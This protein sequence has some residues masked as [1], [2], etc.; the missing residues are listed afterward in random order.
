M[1][2]LTKLFR[3]IL[4]PVDFDANS[5]GSLEFAGKIAQETG[6][7]IYLLHVVPWTVAAVPIDA[8][9]VLA[10]LKQ[11]ATTRLRQLAKEKLDGRVVSEIIVTVASDPGAEVVRIAK[12]L[13][14]DAIIMATHGRKGLSH[15]V[16]GSVAERVVR[17]SLCPV[18]TVRA[19]G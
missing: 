10:E 14:A 7:K 19:V 12:E 9:Q 5:P 15:L 17:E 11:S 16:L 8:S 6:G 3:N 4:C 1:D 2:T 13:K 18:L